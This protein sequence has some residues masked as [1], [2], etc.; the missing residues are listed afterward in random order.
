MM[1]KL[2]DVA[3]CPPPDS[4][5]IPSPPRCQGPAAHCAIVQ[6]YHVVCDYHSDWLIHEKTKYDWLDFNKLTDILFIDTRAD[7]SDLLESRTSKLR[8]A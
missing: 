1:S 7:S 5:L 3:P 8:S 2:S 6:I 4:L